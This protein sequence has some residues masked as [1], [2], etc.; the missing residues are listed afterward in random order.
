MTAALRTEIATLPVTDLARRFGTPLFVYDA[1]TI[2]PRAWA[3]W[4][5]STTSA[6][7]QKACSNLAILDL[8]R[9]HGALVDTVSARRDSPRPG[10]RLH[11]RGRTAADRLHG[12]HLRRRGPRLVRQRRHPRQLRLAGHDRS[13]RP[14]RRRAAD[15]AADQPRL[16]PRPQPQD[17]HRRRPVETRHLARADR[18]LP[19][20]R[21]A[22][23]T[24]CERA[25]H[26]HR[27]RH[28]PGAPL[29]GLCGHGEGGCGG[30]A[31]RH[32]DQRRR[33]TAR[34]LSPRRALRRSGGLLRP[35]GRQPGAAGRALRPRGA[36]WKSSP[37]D[38]WWPRAA[39][40]WRR[41]G[42]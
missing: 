29:P 10:R 5:P 3:T 2:L 16:R 13:V 8:L 37:A 4:P 15:H 34:P 20:P 33:R 17:Q 7:A 26:A 25:A 39:T 30:R 19:R 14:A 27:L 28:G 41:S 35:L 40:W 31:Q 18:R 32:V 22:L 42:R 6:I 21:R 9:R 36:A 1:A 12:R 24:G 23:R 38:T 11:G